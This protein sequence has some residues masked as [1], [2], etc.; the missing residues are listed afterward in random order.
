MHVKDFM[1]FNYNVSDI[2][3]AKINFT[4]LVDFEYYLRSVRNC[5][6]NSAIKYIKDLGKIV[7]ISLGNGWLAVDPYLNY[8]PKQN[9]LTP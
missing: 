6:N 1:Q 2:P 4:F 7:R 5:G 8:K 9:T 3:V